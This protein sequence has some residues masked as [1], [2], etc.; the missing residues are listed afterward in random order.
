MNI[1]QPVEYLKMQFLVYVLVKVISSMQLV[2]ILIF[3]FLLV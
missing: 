3:Q 2:G 1:F